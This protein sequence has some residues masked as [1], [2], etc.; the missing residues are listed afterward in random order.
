MDPWPKGYPRRRA[1]GPISNRPNKYFSCIFDV[2]CIG[3][4]HYSFYTLGSSLLIFCTTYIFLILFPLA[5]NRIYFS[6]HMHTNKLTSCMQQAYSCKYLILS[7]LYFIIYLFYFYFL[8]L[9][10]SNA[11][12][13]ISSLVYNIFPFLLIF[14][15][16]FSIFFLCECFKGINN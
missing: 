15:I 3:L 8:F 2:S 7:F 6:T 10:V 9:L 11:Q 13:N 16:L 4:V 5:S 12:V 14:L 1:R